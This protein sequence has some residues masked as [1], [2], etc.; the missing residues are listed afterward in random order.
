M[1]NPSER[2][3]VQ[4]S[5]TSV[6]LPH[7][8]AVFWEFF[9]RMPWRGRK[10]RG[11]ETSRMTPL[12]IRAFGPPSYGTFF[13]PLGCQCSVFPVQESTTEQTSHQKLFWRGPKIFGRAR[14]LVRYPPPYVLHP[15]ISRPNFYITHG[16]CETFAKFPE[17]CV[18]KISAG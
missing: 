11:V 10:R 8:S 2:A 13:T 17:D 5:A 18:R 16:F 3:L 12:P 6:K 7:A 4:L 15:P 9:Q 14:S 1:H